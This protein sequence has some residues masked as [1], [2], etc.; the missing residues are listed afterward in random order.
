MATVVWAI[1]R[2][3]QTNTG[4]LKWRNILL[5]PFA[6]HGVVTWRHH[7]GIDKRLAAPALKTLLKQALTI[8]VSANIGDN[9]GNRRREENTEDGNDRYGIARCREKHGASVGSS[10]TTLAAMRVT[11][12][13]IT[14]RLRGSVGVAARR[15]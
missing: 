5:Q 9:A 13:R 10:A 12:N 15:V 4:R 8:A 14:V 1:M 2:R 3:W 11:A 6:C 7:L